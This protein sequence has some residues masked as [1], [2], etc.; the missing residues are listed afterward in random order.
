MM[1][2][3]VGKGMDGQNADGWMDDLDALHD[4][5]PSLSRF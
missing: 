5:F 2:G 4:G 1:V 3:E